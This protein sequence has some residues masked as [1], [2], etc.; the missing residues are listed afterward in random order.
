MDRVKKVREFRLN[1]PS[2]DTNH[3]A[4]KPT[5]PVRL[6]YYSE[7]RNNPALALPKVSSQNRRYIPMEV[8]DADV[9]AGSKLFLIPDISL[10]HFGVLTSNVHM[11][12]M[13]T[14][15]G[16]LK[17]DYSYAS[18]VVYNT[19]P[20]PIPTEQQKQKIAQTAQA[21]T[22]ACIVRPAVLLPVL[23]NLNPGN[24]AKSEI[25]YKGLFPLAAQVPIPEVCD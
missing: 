8:I 25:S 9:I 24:T 14:V 2:P 23:R 12:W 11:A 6:R 22:S 4:D 7:E 20:W 19:F 3:Y 16:R 15:C 5:Y 21:I 10:Y 1:C 13:R 18:N 17:S